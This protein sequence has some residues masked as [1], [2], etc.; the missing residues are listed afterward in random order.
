MGLRQVP[1]PAKLLTLP[2]VLANCE[3]LNDPVASYIPDDEQGQYGGESPARRRLSSSAL[4]ASPG[5]PSGDRPPPPGAGARL[6]GS[7]YRPGYVGAQLYGQGDEHYHDI[8][9]VVLAHIREG[10]PRSTR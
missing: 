2:C 8:P 4:P 1:L 10:K 7:R 6:P 5:Q 3:S 9:A